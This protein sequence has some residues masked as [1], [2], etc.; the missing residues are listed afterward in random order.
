MINKMLNSANAAR[1]LAK[2]VKTFAKVFKLLFVFWIIATMLSLFDY[3]VDSVFAAPPTGVETAPPGDCDIPKRLHHTPSG[4]VSHIQS[5]IE[6]GSYKSP[7]V[8]QLRVAVAREFVPHVR[9]AGLITTVTVAAYIIPCGEWLF[10]KYRQIGGRLRFVTHYFPKGGLT[11]IV[12]AVARDAIKYLWATGSRAARVLQGYWSSIYV[13][14]IPDC[15]QWDAPW[16][17]AFSRC[18]M[19]YGNPYVVSD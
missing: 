8:G 18:G 1:L 15:V 5:L 14:I 9:T 12:R 4:W 17:L 3:G 10:I 6:N 7:W 13:M 11:Y 2:F 19:Y 16:Y